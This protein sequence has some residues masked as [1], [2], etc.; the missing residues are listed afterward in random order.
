MSNDRERLAAASEIDVIELLERLWHRKSLI[1][2][3]ALVVVLCAAAYAFLAPQVY[4]AKIFVRAPTQN[5]IAN[6]NYGRD[7]SQGLRR[8]TVQG[9]YDIYLRNLLSE[10]LRREFFREVYLPTLGQ[11]AI[12]VGPEELYNRYTRILQVAVVGKEAPVRYAI[13]ADLPDPQRA[14]DWVV[15]YANMAGKNAKQEVLKDARS[16]VIVKA[17]NLKQQIVAAREEAERRREDRIVQLQEA[18]AVAQ[19]IGLE[20]PPIISGTLSSEVSAGMDGSLTYMRGARA[21]EA[22]ID[23]LQKRASD[24][25]F[26]SS[27]RAQQTSLA[28][29]RTL[30]IAPE[31]VSVYRLDGEVELPDEPIR[32]KRL[33]VMISGAVFGLLLGCI[34]ASVSHLVGVR[35]SKRSER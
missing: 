18:L 26:I 11:S 21:L 5:D 10:S 32:P 6:L 4:Q 35:A 13:T 25:P 33:L 23:N 20:K 3:T 27:L 24:D 29:Y 31:T 2:G 19:S 1:L 8:L 17:A 34:L 14:A 12:G 22:E 9:V 28:F 15:L 30:E 7:D 16:E